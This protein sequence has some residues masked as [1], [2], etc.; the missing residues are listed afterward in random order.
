MNNSLK[1]VDGFVFD[2]FITTHMQLHPMFFAAV[3]LP[4]GGKALSLSALKNAHM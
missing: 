1:K 4:V 2:Q 3:S